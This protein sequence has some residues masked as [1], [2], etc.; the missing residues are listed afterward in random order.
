M[1]EYCDYKYTYLSE[2]QGR[3]GRG[4]GGSPTPLC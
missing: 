2:G 1:F 3:V 4:G